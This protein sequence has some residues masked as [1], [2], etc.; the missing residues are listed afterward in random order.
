MPIEW[1]EHAD[2]EKAADAAAAYVIA[3]LHAA[4]VARGVAAIAVSGG[5]TPKI[6]FQKMAASPAS[7]DGIHFFWVDE[8]SV[9][10]LHPDSNYGMARR[11]LLEPARIPEAQIHRIQGEL[12]PQLAAQ[13]YIEDI[14]GFFKLQN[15]ALPSFDVL[16]LGLGADGHTASLFPGGPLVDDRAGIAAAVYV[17]KMHTWRITLLPGV[18]LAAR[19]VFYFTGG[20]DKAAIIRTVTEGPL[21]PHKWPSQV[22]IRSDRKV[23]WFVGGPR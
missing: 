14:R 7:W 16:Q 22:V 1:H 8:R 21:D 18:L 20:G 5:S 4:R 2:L 19:E 11:A 9:P 6:L 15:G 13:K 12:D 17:E 3:N 10:P 23:V